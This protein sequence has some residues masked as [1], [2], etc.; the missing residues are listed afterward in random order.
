[1]C[2]TGPWPDVATVKCKAYVCSICVFS[3][4]IISTQYVCNLHNF[5]FHFAKCNMKYLKVQ[6]A[7]PTRF[8]EVLNLTWSMPKAWPMTNQCIKLLWIWCNKCEGDICLN[9]NLARIST[10]VY[11][12]TNTIKSKL[13][14]TLLTE[15][16][17]EGYMEGFRIAM[18]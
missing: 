15:E 10:L 18:M 11:G 8:L 16:Y 9:M 4:H 2:W 17:Y 12:I 6:V 3:K 5:I 14:K 1:M 7:M 13:K